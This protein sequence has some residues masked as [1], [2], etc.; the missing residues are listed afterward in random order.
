M[1]LYGYHCATCD[2][3]V[4]LLIRASDTPVCPACGGTALERLVSRVAP[5]GRSK[6]LITSAR[7]QAAREGHFSHYGRSERPR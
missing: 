7:A 6:G 4:E 5:E 3:D 2:K 1:P